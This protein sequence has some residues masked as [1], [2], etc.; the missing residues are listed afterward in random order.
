MTQ[1]NMGDT[2]PGFTLKVGESGSVTL[3]TDIETDF[4]IILFYRG[5]W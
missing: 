5:H 2:L 1:L 3:P 4:A